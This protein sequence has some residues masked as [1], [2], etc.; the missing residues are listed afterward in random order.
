MS[1]REKAPS[2]T[3]GAARRLLARAREELKKD[4]RQAAEKGWLAAATAARAI[5]RRAGRPEWKRVSRIEENLTETLGELKM[6]T[7]TGE[8]VGVLARALHGS[9]FYKGDPDYTDKA[10]VEANFK[11]VER[12]I[13]DAEAFF[14]LRGRRGYDEE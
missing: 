10:V 14:R 6:S 13:G 7:Q 2:P 9:A 3:P 4:P 11:I 8:D 12:V 1:R 5:L